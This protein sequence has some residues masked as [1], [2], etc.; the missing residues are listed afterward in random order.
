M[1]FPQR[2][3]QVLM[4]KLSLPEIIKKVPDR[5]ISRHETECRFCNMLWSILVNN[6]SR[7]MNSYDR[8][9]EHNFH[10]RKTLETNSQERQS[11]TVNVQEEINFR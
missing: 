8:G 5:T 6:N 7:C 2:L 1:A 4:K 3:M 11:S 10:F 9:G